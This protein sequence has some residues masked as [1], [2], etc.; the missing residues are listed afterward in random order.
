[1]PQY[2]RREFTKLALM[3][4]PAAGFMSASNSLRGAEMPAMPPMKPNSLINGVQLGLNVPYSFGNNLMS[5]DETLKNLLQLGFSA[6]ELRSQPVEGFMGAPAPA[7]RAGRG[8][9]KA[10]GEKKYAAGA[11]PQALRDFRLAA[12][13]DRAK[14]FRKKYEDAGVLIQIVK[15]DN[16]YQMVDAELDYAF[17][18]ARTLGARAISCEIST[19]DDDL[20]RLGRFA[21]KHELPVGYHGHTHV[22]PADWE[23]AFS[24]AKH[25]FANLDIGH[26]IAGNHYSPV[27]FLKKHHDRITHV[28]IKDRK[29][30]GPNGEAEGPN[31][32]FGQGDTPIAEVLRLMR[33]NKWTMQATIEFEYR[34]P[35]GSTRM[36]EIERALS[37]CCGA[38]A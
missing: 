18:L 11:G 23:H 37:Y 10:E 31:V 26:F 12:S 36:A 28:H 2:T 25:N 19:K 9:G 27:E 13:M 38:L 7:G 17:N 22:A 8:R 33:D 35:E 16:I 29:M 3:A 14:E 30:H 5:G 1:M 20:K 15:F 32:V 21:D 4:L 34:V 6:V 24:F